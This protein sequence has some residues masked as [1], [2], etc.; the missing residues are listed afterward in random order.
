MTEN[1]CNEIGELTNTWLHKTMI[2]LSRMKK[3][4]RKLRQ[5]WR[6]IPFYRLLKVW[7]DWVITG[8]V[9][10]EKAINLFEDIITENIVKLDINN[11][12]IGHF[13]YSSDDD[14]LVTYDL[15]ADYIASY[16]D[17]GEYCD[18]KISDYAI[19]P[20]HTLLEKLKQEN[21]YR[22]KLVIIDCILNVS[23]QRSDLAAWFVEGGSRSLSLL[24]AYNI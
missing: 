1:F 24:S 15:T 10:D 4:G 3:T 12:L 19:K 13:C 11:E 18:W 2:D 22:Q 7:R 16:D 8:I 14:D 9:R 23:H 17:I 6:L 5:P 21:D 20:L